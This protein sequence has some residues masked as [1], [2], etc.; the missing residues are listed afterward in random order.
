MERRVI[1]TAT[2]TVQAQHRDHLEVRLVE[3]TRRPHIAREFAAAECERVHREHAHRG[4]IGAAVVR[5][6]VADDVI[7]ERR[8]HHLPLALET[9]GELR[10]AEQAEFLAGVEHERDARIEATREVLAHHAGELHDCHRARSVIVGAGGVGRV[11]QAADGADAGVVV[12]A[13]HDD[14]RGVTA[15]EPGDDVHQMRGGLRRVPCDHGA[16][17]VVFHA[18]A[19]A[20]VLRILRELRMDVASRRADAARGGEC[21]A[22]GMSRAERDEHG[23]ERA[24]PRRRDVGQRRGDARVPREAKRRRRL[25]CERGRGG[26]ERGDQKGAGQGHDSG[27]GGKCS[28]CPDRHRRD[29]RGVPLRMRINPSCVTE[30]TSFPSREN[31]SPRTNPRAPYAAG[32]SQT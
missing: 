29:H 27:V 24:E 16:A 23:V 18:Q 8:G 22:R 26:K 3:R 30:A 20:A 19:A 12:A 32:L 1:A 10:R 5:D 31:T 21:V 28:A 25:G 11:V 17:G 15:R 13:D 4:G 6:H 7:G 14:A 9:L 2:E